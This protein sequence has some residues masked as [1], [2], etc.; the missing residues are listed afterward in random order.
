MYGHYTSTTPLPIESQT[1]LTTAKHPSPSLSSSPLITG[2]LVRPKVVRSAHYCAATGKRLFRDYRDA[3][4][5]TILGA[6]TTT[7]Y[8]TRD[9]N[10]NPLT[11]EF[12][13]SIYKDH[14]VV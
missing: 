8:P 10:E 5:V 12:G 11:T 4:S 13:L 1:K 7:A 9:E 2:S 6:P 3:T 14:Q